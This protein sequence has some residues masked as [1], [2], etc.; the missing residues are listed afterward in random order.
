MTALLFIGSVIIGFLSALSFGGAETVMHQIL[1]AIGMLASCVLFAAGAI[2]S[3]LSDVQEAVVL[4]NRNSWNIGMAQWQELRFPGAD[5]PV[6]VALEAGYREW[7]PP[8][9]GVSRTD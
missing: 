1:S 5:N 2:V 8:V 4:T 3:K 7:K 9:A 6:P